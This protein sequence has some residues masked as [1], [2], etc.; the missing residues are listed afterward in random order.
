MVE[1]RFCLEEVDSRS[2]L[3]RE[4]FV[5][6][7]TL[8]AL[9]LRTKKRTK[10]TMATITPTASSAA[11]SPP[12]MA[13]PFTPPPEPFD[14]SSVVLPTH[15]HTHTRLVNHAAVP[16]RGRR[17]TLTN[18]VPLVIIQYQYWGTT[19]GKTAIHVCTHVRT[20]SIIVRTLIEIYIQQC[21]SQR[22]MV[23][24]TPYLST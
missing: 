18:T 16:L 2:S 22:N 17:E 20:A 9:L 5:V 23:K 12:A 8:S 21:S 7:C 19:A 11:M 3:G 14:T 15:T 6:L 4:Y 10:M 24:W 13:P 1:K